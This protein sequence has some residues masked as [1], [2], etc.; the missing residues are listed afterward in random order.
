M[1]KRSPPSLQA[2]M[3]QNQVHPGAKWV[4][5]PLRDG[6]WW[7]VAESNAALS[8]TAIHRKPAFRHTKGCA[9]GGRPEDR[10]TADGMELRP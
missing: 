1:W 6:D 9:R 5:Q 10:S 7:N 8:A 2:R 3:D 4:L